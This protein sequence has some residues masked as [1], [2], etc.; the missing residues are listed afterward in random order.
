[1]PG[2]SYGC[3]K[4]AEDTLNRTGHIPTVTNIARGAGYCAYYARLS[5]AIGIRRFFDYSIDHYSGKGKTI[6]KILGLSALKLLPGSPNEETIRNTVKEVVSENQELFEN[7]KSFKESRE[8]VQDLAVFLLNSLISNLDRIC[9]LLGVDKEE[10]YPIVEQQLID[11]DLHMRGIPDLILESMEKKKAIVVEWKTYGQNEMKYEEAQAIAYSLLEASRLGLNDRKAAVLGDRISRNIDVIPVVIKANIKASLGPHPFLADDFSEESYRDF[12]YLVDDVILEAEHLT[13]LVSDTRSFGGGNNKLCYTDMSWG[14]KHY[15]VNMLRLTPDQLFKGSPSKQEKWPCRTKNGNSFCNLMEP[16]KFYFGRPLYEQD[17]VERDMWLLR[18]KVFENK[19]RSLSVYRAIYDIFKLYR[20]SSYEEDA[21][22]HF[23]K[24]RGFLY[25]PGDF[26]TKINDAPLIQIK[27]YEKSRVELLDKLEIP[28]SRSLQLRGIR[29]LRNF[30]K[31]NK[32]SFV[33]PSGRTVLLTIMDS[34]NPLL[35]ISMFGIIFEVD[36]SEDQIEYDIRIPSTILDFQMI[37]FMSYLNV[38][39]PTN[40][41]MF[42]VGVDLTQ[43]ELN[44][45]NELQ[46]TLKKRENEGEL[47]LNKDELEKESKTEEQLIESEGKEI[48]KE[49]IEYAESEGLLETLASLVKRSAKKDEGK[50]I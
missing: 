13:L 17:D 49:G 34:W 39:K 21:M 23:R 43:M 36:S 25:S 32:I 8:G 29:K 47:K 3:V 37:I 19:E 10:I 16:C 4:M 30:E 31:D 20:N 44:S 14:G 42:E 12:S 35:S 28:D 46:R 7:D 9:R 48:E 26:P 27:N 45:I 6:H 11:Y 33:V 40:I 18:F 38:K 15:K 1:M 22:T 50:P 2:G 24:G 5:E 41:L